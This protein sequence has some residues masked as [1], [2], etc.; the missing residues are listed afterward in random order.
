MTSADDAVTCTGSSFEGIQAAFSADG[1]AMHSH[2]VFLGQFLMALFAV[3][4]LIERDEGRHTRSSLLAKI[5]QYL[6]MGK[7]ENM[8]PKM[9]KMKLFPMEAINEFTTGNK[10]TSASHVKFDE[11]YVPYFANIGK[12]CLE[13]VLQVTCVFLPAAD[14]ELNLSYLTK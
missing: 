12:N 14:A 1:G 8:L 5:D 3:E 2:S 4:A 11:E 10:D 13:A 9:L 6:E 7:I